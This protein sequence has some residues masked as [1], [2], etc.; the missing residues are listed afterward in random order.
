MKQK[1]FFLS[2][3]LLLS[4]QMGYGLDLQAAK[5][6]GLVGETP[7]GYLAVVKGG[8]AE[9]EALAQS[10][11]AQRRQHYEEIAKRNSTQLKA[12]EE[13]A[14]KKAVEKTPAGQWI[15]LDGAWKKK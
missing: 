14:G 8:N 15:L 10:I 2:V 1:I 3:L 11:N 7:T 4:A 13:L 9:A 12:V 5:T 6:Q